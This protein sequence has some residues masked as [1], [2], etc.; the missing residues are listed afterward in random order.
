MS[1]DHVGLEGPSGA[2]KSHHARLLHSRWPAAS[3]YYNSKPTASVAGTRCRRP[4]RLRR[5]LLTDAGGTSQ[6]HVDYRPQDEEAELEQVVEQLLAWARS[7]N[8]SDEH[9]PGF[10]LVI[11]EAAKFD[12]GKGNWDP[13]QEVAQQG[14]EHGLRLVAGYQYPTALTTDTRDQLQVI[15]VHGVGRVGIST[16]RSKGFYPD[17]ELIPWVNDGYQWA[18][19]T[20]DD[21]WTLRDALPPTGDGSIQQRL[22]P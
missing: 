11:D 6:A 19:W 17:D 21:G 16:V 1:L 12:E 4:E 13:V 2:G 18:M 15:A 10:Q 20:Q 8:A 14:R 7:S 9:N 5:A 3:V 22:G